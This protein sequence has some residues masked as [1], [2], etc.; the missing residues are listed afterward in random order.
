MYLAHDSIFITFLWLNFFHSKIN[1]TQRCIQKRAAFFLSN[2]WLRYPKFYRNFSVL[3]R[4]NV[5]L[6]LGSSIPHSF[7]GY[8]TNMSEHPCLKLRIYHRPTVPN[9]EVHSCDG[10]LREAVTLSWATDKGLMLHGFFAPTSILL[11]TTKRLSSQLIA[12]TGKCKGCHWDSDWAQYR[13]VTENNRTSQVK[14]FWFWW[15]I[16]VNKYSLILAE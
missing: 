11:I 14:T 12:P 8:L 1:K 6:G 9:R 13:T 4:P 15:K 2:I 7:S 5:K 3:L 16:N 10:G